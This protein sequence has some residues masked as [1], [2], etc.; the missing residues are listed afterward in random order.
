M[1]PNDIFLCKLDLLVQGESLTIRANVISSM[2]NFTDT[3]P[4]NNIIE[5]I[6]Y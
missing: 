2:N 4:N 5:A 1:E 6:H 3:R